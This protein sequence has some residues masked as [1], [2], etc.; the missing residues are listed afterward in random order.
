MKKHLFSF[1]MITCGFFINAQQMKITITGNSVKF[2]TKVDGTT[3]TDWTSAP[4]NLYA[5]TD[6]A[7][8][9]PNQ[10]ASTNVLGAYP[11]TNL[12]ND[13]SGNYTTTVNLSTLFPSGTKINNIKFIYN[14]ATNQNPGGGSSGFS[15]TDA[16]HATG[17]SPVTI[18]TLAVNDLQNAK[19]NTFVANGKL[20]TKQTGNLDITIYDMSGKVIKQS[21]VKSSG[22]ALDLNIDQRGNYMVKVSNGSETEVVKF[23]K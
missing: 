20:Y 22:S 2:S 13:G 14:Y 17:W 18:S 1:L 4:V 19:K 21:Q 16:A 10:A 8:T 3:G 9:A 12:V 6:V 15:T 7:D 5:Y 11:G 23:I